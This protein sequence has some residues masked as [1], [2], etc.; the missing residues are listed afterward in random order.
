MN[1]QRRA[2]DYDV[3]GTVQVSSAPAV[4]DAVR[5]IFSQLY[6]DGDFD[7]MPTVFEDFRRLFEG[8]LP[9][10]RGCDTVYHDLQHTLDI[11][12]AF[13]RLVGG[14]ERRHAD[15]PLGPENTKLGLVTALFHDSGYILRDDDD[16][17]NGAEY[18][19]THVT[20]GAQFMAEYFPTVGLAHMVAPATTIVHFTGYEVNPDDLEV[21]KPV[22]RIIGQLVG[23]ADLVAQMADRC[24]LEKCRDRLFTE[25]VLG[26]LVETTVPDEEKTYQSGLDLLKKTPAFFD[27]AFARLDGPLDGVYR[28]FSDWFGNGDPYT[29][30]IQQN[31]TYLEKVLE[32]GD[33]SILR[34]KPPVFTTGGQKQLED[35]QEIALLRLRETALD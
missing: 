7:P 11:T 33:W 3:T 30:S 25:F 17:I 2:S 28:Y 27:N 22:H 20:R 14:Y 29:E 26:G 32:A 18:T 15:N 9:G 12:L 13:M 35:T 1:K 31:R 10:Y 4:R 8:E 5:A 24:Y 19:R 23:S 34:R 6:P 16:R 21:D